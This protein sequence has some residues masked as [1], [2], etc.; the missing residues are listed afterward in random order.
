MS[1]GFR[2]D[3]ERC[4]GC[5]ACVVACMDQNAPNLETGPTFRQV[6][7]VE[8]SSHERTQI[9]YVSIACMNCESAPCEIACPTGAIY[10][11]PR[12]GIVCVRA[13]SCIGCH[14]CLIA[15]PFGV[16]RFG[17]DGRMQKCNLCLERVAAGDEP[18]CSRVCPTKALQ[19]GDVGELATRQLTRAAGR[20]AEASKPCGTV[21]ETAT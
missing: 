4:S 13:E 20:L 3:I 16:P 6:I 19:F 21:W 12:S 5:F 9:R 7:Q 8:R 15:C 10:R 1:V 2:L 17:I 11:D 14:S 18:A